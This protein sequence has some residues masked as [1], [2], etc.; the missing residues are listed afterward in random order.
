[1]TRGTV[2]FQAFTHSW[3]I[4]EWSSI[5]RGHSFNSQKFQGKN[6]QWYLEAHKGVGV[7]N[8]HVGIYLHCGGTLFSGSTNELKPIIEAEIS[9]L[10]PKDAFVKSAIIA[11]NEYTYDLDKDKGVGFQ[12]LVSITDILKYLDKDTLNISVKIEEIEP[13]HLKV[14]TISL[15]Q[16]H[17]QFDSEKVLQFHDVSIRVFESENENEDI[18]NSQVF[19]SSR[20]ILAT[21]SSFFEE[22]FTSGMKE[23]SEKEIILRGVRPKVFERILQFIHKNKADIK[24]VSDSAELM[25]EADKLMIKRLILEVENYLQLRIN[26]DTLWKIWE[27]ADNYNCKDLEENCKEFLRDNCTKLFTDPEWIN[28]KA[29]VAIKALQINNL[30][31]KLM[32]VYFLRLF[33]RGGETTL[34]NLKTVE[35]GIHTKLILKMNL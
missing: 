3:L 2:V 22:L 17:L 28:V 26:H 15:D 24:G 13:R 10:P 30:K 9:I 31:K 21:V 32:K 18:S 14:K 19:H 35:N 4:P 12:K 5:P 6:Y 34:I 20:L 16:T 29:N 11:K 25:K 33:F 7:N 1:M 27:I 23:S 8:E